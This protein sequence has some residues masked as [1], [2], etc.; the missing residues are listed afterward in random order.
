MLECQLQSPLSLLY[1]YISPQNFE[2][3]SLPGRFWGYFSPY[4]HF[5]SETL[6]IMPLVWMCSRGKVTPPLMTNLRKLRSG[7]CRRLCYICPSQIRHWMHKGLEIEQCSLA[8][9]ILRNSEDTDSY[10]ALLDFKTSMY[11]AADLWL[12]VVLL[13]PIISRHLCTG[14][15]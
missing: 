10:T 12:T 6:P 1:L 9:C 8:I 13:A 11:S 14:G 4:Y 15:A 7:E 3:M 2:F 5:G